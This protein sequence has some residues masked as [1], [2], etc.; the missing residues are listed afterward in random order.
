M[1]IEQ[2][3]GRARLSLTYQSLFGEG[4]RA[5]IRLPA[6]VSRPEA[7]HY[8]GP[9]MRALCACAAARYVPSKDEL[10]SLE[11]ACGTLDRFTAACEELLK[12]ARGASTDDTPLELALEQT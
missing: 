6:R 12:R 11:L 4:F 10:E 1:A 5:R 2:R 3:P 9:W 7:A 8:H